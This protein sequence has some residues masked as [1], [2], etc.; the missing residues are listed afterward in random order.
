MYEVQDD[1]R[2]GQNIEPPACQVHSLRSSIRGGGILDV[3][4]HHHYGLIWRLRRMDRWPICISLPNI[5]TSTHRYVVDDGG[6]PIEGLWRTHKEKN[7]VLSVI[8]RMN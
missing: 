4:R 7:E 5:V 6:L 2:K 1:K 8:F 3:E